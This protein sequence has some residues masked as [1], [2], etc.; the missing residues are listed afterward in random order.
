MYFR[1]LR[2][3]E[4]ASEKSSSH[5]FATSLFHGFYLQI[6]G[7]AKEQKSSAPELDKRNYLCRCDGK[8]LYKIDS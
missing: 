3:E 2:T 7:V 5:H 1:F 6:I 4:R 8:K